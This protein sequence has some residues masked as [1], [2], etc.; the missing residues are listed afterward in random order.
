[1]KLPNLRLPLMRAL[2][3]CISCISARS[4]KIAETEKCR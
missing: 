1:M 4:S 3:A 2:D